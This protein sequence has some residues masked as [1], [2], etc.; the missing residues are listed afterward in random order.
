MSWQ[1]DRTWNVECLLCRKANNHQIRV[2]QRKR[3]GPIT[4]RS[5]DRNLALIR[6]ASEYVFSLLA[7]FPPSLIYTRNKTQKS[8]IHI[9]EFPF[10]FFVFWLKIISS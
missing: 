5:Q 7:F 2:A 4:H 9:A 6:V 10:I 8:D 1:E 3:G